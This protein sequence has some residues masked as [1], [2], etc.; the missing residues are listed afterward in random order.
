LIVFSTLRSHI[1]CRH[2]LWVQKEEGNLAGAKQVYYEITWGREASLAR[3]SYSA[4]MRRGTDQWRF[5][6]PWS[7]LIGHLVQIK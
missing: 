2:V 5:R 4:G 7:I 1:T 6:R 3:G